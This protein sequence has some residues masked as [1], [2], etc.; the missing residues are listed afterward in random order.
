MHFRKKR[1]PC[2]TFNF[3]CSNSKI[4]YCSE[5]KYL[6]LWINEYIDVS[7]MVDRVCLATRKTLGALIANGIKIW[8]VFTMIP[9]LICITHLLLL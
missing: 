8:A 3:I 4:E 9:T 7:M 1:K 5:Y 2:S 6:G